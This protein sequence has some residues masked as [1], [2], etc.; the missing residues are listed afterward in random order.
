MN[1]TKFTDRDKHKIPELRH[2]YEIITLV[3]IISK[4]FNFKKLAY[5]Y[6]FQTIA[7]GK[8]DQYL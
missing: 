7:F 5:M 8:K 3:N 4:K 1:D 6:S 2:L